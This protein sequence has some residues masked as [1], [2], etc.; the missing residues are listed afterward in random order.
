M[1][2]EQPWYQGNPG[3]LIVLLDQSGSM[4]EPVEGDRQKRCKCDVAA[5]VVNRTLNRLVEDNTTMD[6][7]KDRAEVAV[8]GYGESGVASAL[9]G[10]AMAGQSFAKLSDLAQNFLRVDKRE[11]RTV[12]ASGNTIVVTTEHLVWVEPSAS[13]GTPLGE[14]F[15]QACTLAKE[16][17]DAHPNGHPP[18]VVNVSDGGATD[19]GNSRDFTPYAREL[20]SL[21]SS[22]GNV[23]L[24]NIHVTGERRAPIEYPAVLPN[25][26]DVVDDHTLETLARYLFDSASPLPEIIINRM[27]A[28]GKEV[29]QGARGFVF[30]GNGLSL[31]QMFVFATPSAG[32]FDVNR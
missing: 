23:L 9:D 32:D 19:C 28:K 6:A 2:Y 25:L 16:W 1:P 13:G 24:L 11:K 14:A 4:D 10:L 5:E 31:A 20:T 12:D 8:L 29:E 7:V 22:D 27:A 21:A 18:L 17:I 3:C 15:R 26:S 30:N